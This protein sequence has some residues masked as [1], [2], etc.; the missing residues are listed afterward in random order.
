MIL[1]HVLGGNVQQKA[2]KFE[3]AFGIFKLN[4]VF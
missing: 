3:G 4:P 1:W 2:D